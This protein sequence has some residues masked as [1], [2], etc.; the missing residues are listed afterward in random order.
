MDGDSLEPLVRFF[1]LLEGAPPPQ[2]ADRSAGGLLP[3]RAFRYCEAVTAASAL[4]WYAFPPIG[5]SLMWDGVQVGWTYDGA[6]EWYVLERAQF[7]G[8]SAS[9][10]L[11][12]PEAVRG[13]APPFLAA[14]PEPGIVQIWSGLLARTRPDW[15]LLLRAPANLPRP[16]GYDLYEGVVETDRWFGPL[17]TNVRLLKTDVPVRFDPEMPLLQMHPLHRAAY[18]D[19]LLNRFS[20]GMGMDALA[21]SDWAE[22]EATVVRPGAAAARPLGQDA[23]LVRR[24]RRRELMPHPPG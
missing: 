14:L 18:G 10:D 15:S 23:A 9:F 24:R 19:E 17:F 2:R 13:Y 22:Y 11:Q 20:V 4:G 21:A 6:D 12:A 3:T 1:Q 16:A 5:F 8:F 7:P